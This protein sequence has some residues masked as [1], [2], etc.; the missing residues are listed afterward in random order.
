MDKIK[1]IALHIEG[2]GSECIVNAE[3]IES[4]ISGST[5]VGNNPELVDDITT[6]T[7]HSGDFFT[8]EETTEEIFELINAT[9]DE[10]K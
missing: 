3:Q 1:F 7:M 9:E 4:I 8:V 5:C 6:V 2:T 10:N